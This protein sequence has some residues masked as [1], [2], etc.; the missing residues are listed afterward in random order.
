[1]E[2]EIKIKIN[3][4]EELDKLRIELL[5]LMNEYSGELNGYEL[6]GVLDV[7]RRDIHE[8]LNDEK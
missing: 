1:M 7:V 6:L 3:N 5:D 4:G 8:S 2:N